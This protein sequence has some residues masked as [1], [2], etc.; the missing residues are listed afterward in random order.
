VDTQQ[1]RT[2]ES[3]RRQP[4]SITLVTSTLA[5]IIRCLLYAK[6]LRPTKIT[7]ST[8]EY[9]NQKGF[10]SNSSSPTNIPDRRERR[11]A[12]RNAFSTLSIL[13]NLLTKRRV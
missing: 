1:K 12:C 9:P 6:P 7:I 5:C 4:I 8:V 10:N 3:R 13:D 11:I 2:E